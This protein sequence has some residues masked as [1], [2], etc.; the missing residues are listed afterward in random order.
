[1]KVKYDKFYMAMIQDT[2]WSYRSGGG[3]V[4]SDLSIRF[5]T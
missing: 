1:M 2:A 5:T 3:K 4:V